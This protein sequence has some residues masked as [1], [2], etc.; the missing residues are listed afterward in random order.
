M[1]DDS[2]YDIVS[3]VTYMWVSINGGIGLKGN[4]HVQW[5]IYMVSCRIKICGFP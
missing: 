3:Y 2:L 1:V 4:D 5:E